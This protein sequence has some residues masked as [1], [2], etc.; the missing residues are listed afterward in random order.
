METPIFHV[1]RGRKYVLYIP[2]ISTTEAD[3]SR[4]PPGSPD[5]RIKKLPYGKL[6]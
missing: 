2:K 3:F 1:Q 5:L 6:T 4:L